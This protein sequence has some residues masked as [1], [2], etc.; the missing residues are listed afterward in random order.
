LRFVA[1][2]L[3]HPIRGRAFDFAVACAA[4]E[5]SV[6]KAVLCCI[7]LHRAAWIRPARAD[8]AL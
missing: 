1:W 2:D 6:E 3:R 8:A 7:P 4:L 5:T